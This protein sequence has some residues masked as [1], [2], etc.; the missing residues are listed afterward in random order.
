KKR[1]EFNFP[2]FFPER[3]FN[4]GLA[5]ANTVSAAVGFSARGKVPFVVGSSSFL[6]GKAW[7][8]IRNG[9]CYSNLNVKIIGL[10]DEVFEDA[11]LMRSISNMKVFCPASAAEALS[12]IYAL[13]DDYG[14]AYVRLS[15]P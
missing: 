9:I 3:Y 7:E 11:A 8:Q 13:M 12:V 5:E 15:V 10:G 6:I 4:F 14:P 2:K 1:K